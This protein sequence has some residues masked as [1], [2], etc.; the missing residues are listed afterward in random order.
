MTLKDKA[1]GL[2]RT[3]KVCKIKNWNTS[4]KVYDEDD[5]KEAVLELKIYN[6]NICKCCQGKRKS[7]G[8]FR[9]SFEK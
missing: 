4:H 3:I 2:P 1:M 9:W 5:L 7:T 6:S 8:G